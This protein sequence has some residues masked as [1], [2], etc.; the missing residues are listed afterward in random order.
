MASR[1]AFERLFVIDCSG[2]HNF[3]EFVVPRARVDS[4]AERTL[5]RRKSSPAH[6]GQ[7]VNSLSNFALCA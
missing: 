7:A 2:Q 3:A 6:L 1:S 4:G 5:D